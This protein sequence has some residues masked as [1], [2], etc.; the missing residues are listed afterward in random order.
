MGTPPSSLNCLLG[1]SFLVLPEAGAMRV[2]SP[3]A[4]IMTN[5]FI[6]AIS[7]VQDLSRQLDRWE[8]ARSSSL[9]RMPVRWEQPLARRPGPA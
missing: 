2:P 9:D 4:G 5:T 7:T 6:R 1:D 8:G 3:A